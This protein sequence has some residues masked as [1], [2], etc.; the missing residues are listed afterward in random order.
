MVLCGLLNKKIASSIN[1]AGGRA[2]GLSG[3]DDSMVIASKQG[4]TMTDPSSGKL[5]E[6]DLGL[7]GAPETIRTELLT[8]L[9]DGGIV[10]VI[11]PVCRDVFAVVLRDQA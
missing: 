11:A 5:V 2:V 3:K 9:L 4:H 6:V 1:A 7:V 10:P 8:Q